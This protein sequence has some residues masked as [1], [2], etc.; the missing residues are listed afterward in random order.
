MART[1]YAIYEAG[2]LRPLEAL[3]DIAEHAQVKLT[4]ESVASA[5][6]GLGPC[7]GILPDDD[8]AELGQVIE[9]EFERHLLG[10]HGE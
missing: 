4:V 6:E 3:H 1:F 10:T 5:E 7:I 2:L 8:A 9:S